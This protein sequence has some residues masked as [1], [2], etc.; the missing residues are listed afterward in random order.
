MGARNFLEPTFSMGTERPH[1][2]R[3]ILQKRILFVIQG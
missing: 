2:G 1:L 3:K